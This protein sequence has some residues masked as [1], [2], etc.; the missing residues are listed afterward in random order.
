[1]QYL[2]VALHRDCMGISVVCSGLLVV[3]L[4]GLLKYGDCQSREDMNIYYLLYSFFF[5]VD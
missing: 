1:M 3:H 5:L 2:I 4:E